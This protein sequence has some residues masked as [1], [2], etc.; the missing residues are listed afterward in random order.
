MENQDRIKAGYWSI[1]TQKH[2]KEFKTD[3]SNLDEFDK[4][5]I[6]GKTGRFLGAIRGNTQIDSIKKIRKMANQVGISPSEL[7]YIILPNLEK[8]SDK[9]VE[10]IKNSIGE[11]TGIAEYI[12]TNESVLDITGKVFE[13][14]NPTDVQRIVI[15]TMDE[16]KRV[17]YFQDEIKNMMCE[18]GFKEADINLS[19]TLQEQFKLIEKTNKSR[20]PIVSNKYVWGPNYKKI[21]MA[22]SSINFNKK[23][24]LKEAIDI[25]QNHQGHPTEKLPNIDKDLLL[26]AK[27]TGMLVPN[28]IVSGRGFNK[29][30]IFSPN[31][32]EPLTYKDD[33]LDDVKLLLASIRF[34][35]NYTQHSTIRDPAMF[36]KS[37]IQKGDIGPHDANL[38]DYLLLEKKGIVRVVT[39]KKK[40]YNYRYNAYIEKTGPCLELVREDVA[41]EALKFIE[42]SNYN[43]KPESDVNSFEAIN[44][45]GSYI[46]SEE[47][48]VR[49]GES[50]E[51]IKE[52]EE[53]FC[54]VLR[55]E[56]L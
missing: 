12:F 1:A 54:K 9:Q 39:K 14:F 19:L 42:T 22:I 27:K 56:L 17:P 53:Y 33:I 51:Y 48:L 7:E 26:L 52:A 8:S 16:T 34:G 20:N 37:L 13:D 28:T 31:M 24:N 50:P 35:E 23:Q 11:I 44:D 29:E 36:L 3:C 45:T 2:L 32:L 41:K 5:N 55:D 43:I 49:L 40:V 47:T 18:I 4:L 6:A 10:L 46:T 21:A 25:V 15:E 38:T 30:F